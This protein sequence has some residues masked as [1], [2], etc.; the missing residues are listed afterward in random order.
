M[1]L[2]LP[3]FTPLLLLTFA[4][5]ALLLLFI[6]D[7]IDIDGIRIL[8]IIIVGR[9]PLL[10]L[11]LLFCKEDECNENF[12]SPSFEDDERILSLESAYFYLFFVLNCYFCW[13]LKIKK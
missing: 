5:F 4:V 8:G 3:L 13:G 2:L 6:E 7:A 12:F 1:L 10:L 9:K 11:L